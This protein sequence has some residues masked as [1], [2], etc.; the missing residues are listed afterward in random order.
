MSSGPPSPVDARV[1]RDL[2]VMKAGHDLDTT[3][4]EGSLAAIRE[5][6]NISTEYGLH[7]PRSGQRPYSSDAPGVLDWLAHPIGNVPPYLS[8][9]ESVLVDQMDLGDLRG[10]PKVSGGK[11]LRFVLQCRLGRSVSPQREKP[12]RLFP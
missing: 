6:Y 11:T 9:E 4:I 3:V 12:R 1:L 10:M 5:R 8:E 7:V 2:E